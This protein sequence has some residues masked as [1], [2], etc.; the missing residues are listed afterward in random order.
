MLLQIIGAGT[1][2]LPYGLTDYVES[3]SLDRSAD[4]LLDL[5]FTFRPLDWFIA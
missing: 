2:E 1:F 5:Q 4:A 3:K